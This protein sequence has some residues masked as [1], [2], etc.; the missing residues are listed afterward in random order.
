MVVG[1]LAVAPLVFLIMTPPP[2][3][4]AAVPADAAWRRGGFGTTGF[5]GLGAGRR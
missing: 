5:A 2:A 4:K 1:A 3:R